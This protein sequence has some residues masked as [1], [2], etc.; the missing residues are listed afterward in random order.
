MPHACYRPCRLVLI[1][2]GRNVRRAVHHIQPK[3][4]EWQLTAYS[5]AESIELARKQS[6]SFLPNNKLS[7]ATVSND[8]PRS[9]CSQV[10]SYEQVAFVSMGSSCFFRGHVRTPR[11]KCPSKDVKIV[12]RMGIFKSLRVYYWFKVHLKRFK[13][14]SAAI[15][16][17][18]KEVVTDVKFNGVLLRA[19]AVQKASFPKM[20][21]VITGLYY[22]GHL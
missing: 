10:S 12:E 15:L 20:S 14:V 13:C 3:L 19:L 6:Q 4:I 11:Y 1:V 21:V 17:F 9:T 16:E 7:C 2:A 8:P 18:P 5:P 22:R